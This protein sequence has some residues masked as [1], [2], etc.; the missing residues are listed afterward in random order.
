MLIGEF[1]TSNDKRQTE[2]DL[3]IDKLC[4]Y[5][6]PHWEGVQGNTGKSPEGCHVPDWKLYNVFLGDTLADF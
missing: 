6:L 2:L 3:A 1:S 4:D 5:F